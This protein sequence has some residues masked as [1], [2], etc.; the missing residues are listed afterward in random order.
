V[1]AAQTLMTLVGVD[2]SVDFLMKSGVDSEH[3]NATPFGLAL[4]S[5]GITPVQMAVAF[6]VLGNGGVYQE[7]ISV[8]GISDSSR[9]V[10]WDGHQQQE[11][12]QVYRPS[13]AWLVVDM[14]KDAITSGTG[15]KAKIT[16]QTVAGKT[17]TNSDQRGVF[18]CGMTGW[19]SSSLWIGHDNYK[20]LSSKATG[21]NS[22]APLWSEYMQKIHEAKNLANR[23]I[24]E[25]NPEDYSLTQVTTCAVSGQLATDACY[26][27]IMGYGVVTD[28]WYTPTVPTV[29]CQMHVYANICTQTNSIAT[30]YCPSV[31]QRGVVVIPDGH[32]LYRFLNSTLYQPVLS[33]YLG[34]ATNLTY[35]TYHQTANQSGTDPL[36][37]NTLIPDALTLI[38]NAQGLLY[39]LDTAGQQYIDIVNAIGNLQTVIAGTSPGSA[40]VA[41][42]MSLLTQAMAASY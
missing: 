19:Y 22:A 40:D 21:G 10:I 28:Y 16:G 25:G 32:P 4:G 7:P 34:I 13:T 31:A 18:F 2:R 15:T 26:N 5:S 33:E 9:N 39:G 12:R 17:G 20:P 35:C 30:P 38:E 27:D 29:Q 1:S 14:M 23:D 11:R 3:I 6:G 41:G 8:L 37:Q 36:V 24:M 42:A